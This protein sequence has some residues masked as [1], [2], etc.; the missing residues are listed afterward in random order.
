MA[1]YVQGTTVRQCVCVILKEVVFCVIE[2]VLVCYC[3][4]LCVTLIVCVYMSV[5]VIFS[6]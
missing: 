2:C 3:M 5:Y 6:V 1:A 4:C